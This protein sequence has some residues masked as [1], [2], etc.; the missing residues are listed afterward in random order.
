MSHS[1][2]GAGREFPCTRGAI[3]LICSALN[4]CDVLDGP[5]TAFDAYHWLRAREGRLPDPVGRVRVLSLRGNDHRLTSDECGI[6]ARN[7]EAL[8]A[9]DVR[10]SS[11][12]RESGVGPDDRRFL[13]ELTEFCGACALA[14]GCF[15]G[16]GAERGRPYAEVLRAPEVRSDVDLGARIE[17]RCREAEALAQRDFGETLTFTL[18]GL[19]ALDRIAARSARSIEEGDDN[20]ATSSAALSLAAYAGECLRSLHGGAWCRL[21]AGDG[22]AVCLNSSVVIP[23]IDL[24]FR[25]YRD[26]SS[27]LPFTLEEY[28]EMPLTL[29]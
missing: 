4:R 17:R 15:D 25:F 3:E 24:R 5:P 26:A 9:S 28:G 21:V 2:Q 18:A 22:P 13:G 27:A 7:L 12:S 16:S 8:A 1:W 19:A 14:D 29:G 10:W 6:I 20:D 23:L 11:Y